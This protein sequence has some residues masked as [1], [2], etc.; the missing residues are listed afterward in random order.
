MSAQGFPGRAAGGAVLCML[1]LGAFAPGS[2]AQE[3]VAA[4]AEPSPPEIAALAEK[5]AAQLLTAKKQKPFILD[6]TLPGDARCPLGTWLADKISESL[7]Q[8]HP[9]LDVISRSQFSAAL[10]PVEL[11]HDRNHEIQ[12]R[13][14]QARELGAEVIVHGNFAAIPGG[15]GL[16][17]MA[18]DRMS[19]GDSHFEALAELPL[20]SE[21]R[22]LLVAELPERLSIAGAY[23]ASTAG[24][25]SAQCE[26]C[27]APEYTYVA[28]AKRLS[29]VVI[30]QV[31]VSRAGV[32]ENTRIVRAPNPA[33]ANAAMRTVRNWRFKPATNAAGDLVP[34]VVDVAVAFKL[35][36]KQTGKTV[37]VARNS[38]RVN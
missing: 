23:K 30:L 8:A 9:E 2:A 6:L 22:A 28:A 32:A 20:T 15:I 25:S 11:F 1:L 29:G 38:G 17:L 37:A 36:Q 12:A 18:D 4:K 31:W 35:E 14:A 21:M 10:S 26:L 24:I 27:P 13:E 3:V 7:A 19:G 16:T 5:L 33:L 34:V